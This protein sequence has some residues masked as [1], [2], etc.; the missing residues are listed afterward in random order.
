MNLNYLKT[1]NGKILKSNKVFFPGEL[2][3]FQN[4]EK[5]HLKFEIQ[6]VIEGHVYDLCCYEPKKQAMEKYDKLIK[7]FDRKE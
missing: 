7:K 3:L 5:K 1:I 4:N 6:I 2:I